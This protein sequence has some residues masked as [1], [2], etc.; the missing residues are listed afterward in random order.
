MGNIL[1]TVGD[2][3]IPTIANATSPAPPWNEPSCGLSMGEKL[4]RFGAWEQPSKRGFWMMLD[5]C[6]HG[7]VT[8]YA[9]LGTLCQMDRKGNHYVNVGISEVTHI[10]SGVG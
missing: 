5:D 2:L 3:Y 8:G 9:Q 6:F 10:G 4:Q 1:M 7:A